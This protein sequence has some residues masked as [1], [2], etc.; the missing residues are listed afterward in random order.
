MSDASLINI[1]LSGVRAHQAALATTGQNITN[2]STP[3]YTRQRVNLETQV[4]NG[5][6]VGA[7][8]VTI[9]GVE[10]IY[11]AA[12]VGQVRSDT[13]SKARHDEILGQISQIDS[14]LAD[15][16]S[17]LNR[18]FERF[19]DAVQSAADAPTSLPARQLV[20]SESQGLVAQ[21]RAVD[22]RLRD[23]L[24]TVNQQAEGEVSEVNRLAT[25]VAD[26]NAR[27]APMRADDPSTNALLD[28]RDELLRR[29]AEHVDVTTVAEG[30]L[31]VNVF[32]G[33]GQALV[34]GSNVTALEL[35]AAGQV[36]IQSRDGGAR[37][38]V[39][40]HGGSLG[41]LL[42]FRDQTLRPVLAETGRLAL[43]FAASVNEVHAEGLSLRG[44]FGGSLF[45]DVNA[46]AVQ[47][48]RVIAGNE[49]ANRSDVD[50]AL[51]VDDPAALAASDYRLV[52]D[53]TASS[54]AVRRDS[55]GSV[56]ASGSV[57]PGAPAQVSFDGLTLSLDGVVQAGAD[58]LL[59]AAG[60]GVAGLSVA[61]G[62]PRDLALASPLAVA[63]GDGNRGSGRLAVSALTDSANPLFSGD[64]ELVPPLLV[65]FT[66][67][68]SYEILDNSDPLD[69]TALS[70]PLWG[71]PYASGG[72]QPLLPE[73][74]QQLLVSEGQ[75]SGALPAAVAQSP[76]LQP[77]ANGYDTETVRF[78]RTDPGSDAVSD[79]EQVELQA[80]T[81]A[82]AMAAALQQVE[83]VTAAA[84]TDLTITELRDNGLGQPLTVAVN[85]EALVLPAGSGLT[86][87]AD[88]INASSTL[89]AAGITATSDG[90]SL[91]LVAAYGD[92]LT[93]H[94]AGDV[95]DGLTV[96]DAS[97]ATL[98]LAGSG[99]GGPYDTITVG[100]SVRL[101]L[102]A[103][104]TVESDSGSPGGGLFS[105][106]PT[107]LPAA[108]G[109]QATLSGRPEA[110]DSFAIGFNDAGNLDNHNALALASLQTSPTLGDP[111]VTF[112]EAYSSIVELV[113]IRTSQ[114]R[115]DAQAA[116]GL[117]QQSVARRESISGVN[118]DEEAANLIKYEQGYNA[119]ARV[120]SIAKDIFDVL[121]GAV[122]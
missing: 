122:A 102:D 93:L 40:V 3:G 19:F 48:S 60:S 84:R 22:G 83:G 45:A 49:A 31:G 25:A 63:T 2:A 27:L 51:R 9:Q 105:A 8:G 37:T 14:L 32:V 116:E 96:A 30:A 1:G 44:E 16:T 71:L 43:A 64:R 61:V 98:N 35:S 86:D 78:L 21:F 65:R 81:S 47:A 88:A 107:A 92:D 62:D 13:S 10:R 106:A 94:V 89:G 114:A 59:S 69:P 53:A 112:S 52:F 7:Q 70:P 66:S 117:L 91:N 36:Q 5:P 23:Q 110:G 113:G 29:L 99:P 4:S 41:G 54:F 57:S 79:I 46:A 56:V 39:D 38:P 90:T 15:E 97:G 120:V 18:G 75:D 119:S 55:D 80:G 24:Q 42:S 68:T 73:Q 76:D 87:L 17:S 28:Q 72:Q 34:V 109:F 118:L 108:F 33:K 103:E 58:F 104:L 77:A 111:P 6:G 20:L 101:L 115:T 11:D 100:G 26:L 82:R 85:G 50:L 121:L 12:A 67:S 95:S 74:G